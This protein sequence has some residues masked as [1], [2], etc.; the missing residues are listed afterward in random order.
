MTE[1]ETTTNT[2][3]KRLPEL[4]DGKMPPIDVNLTSELV[5]TLLKGEKPAIA[6]LIDALREVDNGSDWKARFLLQTLVIA[7]GPAAQAPQRQMLADVLLD[8]ASGSRPVSVRTFLLARLRLIAGPDM[9][10]KLIPLLA[11]EDPQL[12]DAAATVLVSIG[13]PAKAPLV[14]AHKTAQGRSKEVIGNALAQIP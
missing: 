14:D 1:I 6:G 8:G 12:A 7:V 13:A 10:A 2:L 5:Q 9:V 3:L 4:R 11:A